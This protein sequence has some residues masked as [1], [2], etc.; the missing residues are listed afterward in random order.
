MFE[1]I[2]D[3]DGLTVQQ[4]PCAHVRV[5]TSLK[6]DVTILLD[7]EQAE[8]L[9]VVLEAWLNGERVEPVDVEVDR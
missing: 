4:G 1:T 6:P 9:R 5:Q 8:A 7:P 3:H 2:Y